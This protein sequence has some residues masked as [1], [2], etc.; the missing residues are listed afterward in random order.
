MREESSEFARVCR[1]WFVVAEM[2]RVVLSAY[3]RCWHCFDNE[4]REKREKR[5]R[6]EREEREV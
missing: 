1:S 2:I 5:E 4:K 3:L 6:R